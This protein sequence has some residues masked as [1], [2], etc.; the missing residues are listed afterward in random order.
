VE[1]KLAS[2]LVV[3]LGKALNGDAV[4]LSFVRRPWLMVRQGDSLTYRTKRH[5]VVSCP[6]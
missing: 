5:F 6:R 4:V 2:L 3:T 1:F